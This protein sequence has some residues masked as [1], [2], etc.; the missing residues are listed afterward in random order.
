[1]RAATTRQWPW[2]IWAT[3]VTVYVLAVFHR[4]SLGVAG[5]QASERFHLGP[6]ALSAFTV[7]QIGV[8]AL[9][10]IPTGLLVDRF[11]PRAVL[12]VAAV[13]MGAGQCSSRVVH[14]YP[15]ALPPA[16]ARRGRRDDVRQRAAPGRRPLPG[17]A[18]LAGALLT[19]ALGSAATSS[20][21][22]R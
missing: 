13:L 7:L 17:P 22:C 9:M 6:T 21:R 10:Q 5:M 11:G 16:R 20:P 12:T 4:A 19:A 2:L 14:S 8:Y 18:V 15:L 3:A 1:M